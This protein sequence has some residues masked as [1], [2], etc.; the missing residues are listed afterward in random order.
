M[1]IYAKDIILSTEWFRLAAKKVAGDKAP[2][3][4]IEQSDCASVL[5]VTKDKKVLFVKQY[6]PALEEKTLELPSGHIHDG[7]S[8]EEAARR[9][10]NEET[11]YEARRLELVSVFAADTGRLGNKVW[12]YFAPDAVLARKHRRDKK[13]D[14]CKYDSGK[15]YKAVERGRLKNAL[16]VALVLLCHYQRKIRIGV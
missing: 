11:G 7:E 1:E 10:L 8:P 6:R 12:C 16:D 9:E 5:A 15:L 3:Y 14:V 13:I 4:I 2:H